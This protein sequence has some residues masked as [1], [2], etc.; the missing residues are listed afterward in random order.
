MIEP[1]DTT[2][3]SLPPTCS[4][5][6]YQFSIRENVPQRSRVGRV[7]TSGVKNPRMFIY[8]RDLA[9]LFAIDPT[10]G[11]IT[12]RGRLDHEVAHKYLLN[13]GVESDANSMVGYCQV[14]FLLFMYMFF[15]KKK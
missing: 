1:R 12:T 4:T 3:P 10:D 2:N 6:L 8:P 5:K 7:E 11:V 14:D 15:P 9:D 13:I